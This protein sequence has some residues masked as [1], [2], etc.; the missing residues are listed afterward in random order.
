M[1]IIVT[2]VHYSIPKYFYTRILKFTNDYA[3]ATFEMMNFQAI[4]FILLDT[5]KK[6]CPICITTPENHDFI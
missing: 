2:L 5:R 1:K 4:N 3:M 6:F